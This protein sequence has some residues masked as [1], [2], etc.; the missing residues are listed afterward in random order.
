MK[1]ISLFPAKLARLLNGIR[2]RLYLELLWQFSRRKGA[3]LPQQ[4]RFNLGFIVEEFFHSELR[5]FGGFGSTV[6]NIADHYN[7][8]GKPFRVHVVLPNSLRKALRLEIK[9]YHNTQVLVCPSRGEYLLAGIPRYR[10]L[11]ASMAAKL[12]V[13]IDYYP[14]YERPLRALP[15]IPLLVWIRDPRGREEWEKLASVPMELKQRGMKSAAELAGL[16]DEKKNSMLR[17]LELS[18]RAGRKVIFAANA[19]FLTERAARTYGI[20]DLNPCLLPNPIPIPDITGLTCSPAPS[21]CFIGRLDAQ[22]RFWIVLEL[23]RRFKDVTFYIAGES[24]SPKLVNPIIEKYA[25]LANLKFMGMT[26]GPAKHGLLKTCWGLINAS[27]HEGLPVTFQEA[28]AYGKPLISCLNPDGLT[29]KFGYYTG[30]ITGDGLEEKDL[31]KFFRAITLFLNDERQR[32]EKGRQGRLYIERTHT[33]ENFEKH[34]R[35]I[36]AKEGIHA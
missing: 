28:L 34:L 15:L 13:A 17:I 2:R 7:S 3:P 24:N 21:L 31:E 18:R 29:E 8:G 6:K 14:S 36:L 9:E 26:D 35:D 23:A 19:A 5:G 10:G 27:V 16:A 12:L 32:Q 25:S 22:K 1:I 11:L 4:P 20:K 33:F 30:E